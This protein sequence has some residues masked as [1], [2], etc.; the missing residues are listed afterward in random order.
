[1]SRSIPPPLAVSHSPVAWDDPVPP[2]SSVAIVAPDRVKTPP[3]A[4]ET[5]VRNRLAGQEGVHFL[6]L[7][8]RRVPDGVCLEGVMQ[9]E[10]D[11]LDVSQVVREIAGVERVINR[12]LILPVCRTAIPSAPETAHVS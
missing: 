1:M 6:E 5:Q 11:A 7:V 12:L 10:N 3:H 2:G 9:T 4:I 8:V